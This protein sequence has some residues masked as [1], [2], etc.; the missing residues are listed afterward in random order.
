[1]KR[2]SEREIIEMMKKKPLSNM[3]MAETNLD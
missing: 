1:M 2:L 3:K